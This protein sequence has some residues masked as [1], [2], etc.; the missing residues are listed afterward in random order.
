MRDPSPEND[1]ELTQPVCP[2]SGPNTHSPDTASHTRT[3]L[4]P[5]PDTMRDLSPENDTDHTRS[6]CPV[7]FR[8]HAPPACS[9]VRDTGHHHANPYPWYS[10]SRFKNLRISLLDDV[11]PSASALLLAPDPISRP[12]SCPGSLLGSLRRSGIDR[13][14]ARRTKSTT[15]SLPLPLMLA[16]SV[17]LRQSSMIPKPSALRAINQATFSSTRSRA[18]FKRPAPNKCA[19]PCCRA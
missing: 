17:N 19:T 14:S 2:S 1:T 11:P 6:V 3:V 9:S 10:F 7:I 18:S 13:S 5:D 4:S 12:T 8:K 16:A 15:R